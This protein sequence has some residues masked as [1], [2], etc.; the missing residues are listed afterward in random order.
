MLWALTYLSVVSSVFMVSMVSLNCG[1]IP[2]IEPLKYV[3]YSGEAY[4]VVFLRLPLGDRW[5]LGVRAFGRCWLFARCGII[6]VTQRCV[7]IIVHPCEII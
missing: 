3:R 7:A 5:S 4:G 2:F 1:A 6:S